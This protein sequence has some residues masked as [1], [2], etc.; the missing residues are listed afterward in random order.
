M[1][2][3]DPPAEASAS[4]PVGLPTTEDWPAEEVDSA[5]PPEPQP[6]PRR[7]RLP[8]VLSVVL[9]IVVGVV[10]WIAVAG[11]PAV[12]SGLPGFPPAGTPQPPDEGDGGPTQI[13]ASGTV[14][15]VGAGHFESV[16]FDLTQRS[17]IDGEF[18]SSQPV[19]FWILAS[20]TYRGW[21]GTNSSYG[22]NPASP[23][24]TGPVNWTDGPSVS[25]TLVQVNI[26][27]GSFDLVVENANDGPSA[28]V[29]VV[30]AISQTPFDDS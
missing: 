3:D 30:E 10:L 8:W 18:H 11:I 13:L 28:S 26:G 2:A 22:T 6:R 14:W 4:P 7:S 24:A 12:P 1:D 19:H 9:A 21:S 5:P 15:S 16:W 17:E 27:E 23:D 25:V 20:G 29:T